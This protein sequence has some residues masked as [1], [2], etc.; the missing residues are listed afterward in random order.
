MNSHFWKYS[1]Y[2]I[3][4]IHFKVPLKVVLSSSST[5][6]LFLDQNDQIRN[7]ENTVKCHQYAF[8]E[9]STIPQLYVLAKIF[10]YLWFYDNVDTDQESEEFEVRG[11]SIFDVIVSE[12]VIAL[13]SPTNVAEPFYLC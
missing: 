2:F 12:N 3:S 8:S 4:T 10:R 5:K 7:F 6:F 9:T 1:I 11:N 13:Y